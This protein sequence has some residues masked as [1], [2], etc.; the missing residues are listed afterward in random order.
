VRRR[1]K[2]HA[3]RALGGLGYEV[4]I[5]RTRP[6]RSR[7]EFSVSF[8]PYEMKVPAVAAGA[9]RV[10]HVIGNFYTGGSP[11]LVVDLVE[12]LGD[13]YAQTVL[14]RD[15]PSPP[16]YVAP[17]IR[18]EPWLRT[19]DDAARVLEETRPDLVHVHYLGPAFSGIPMGDWQWFTN[20][21][22]AV[23]RWDGPLV[24]NVNI[25]IA[26]HVSGAVD[27]YV[28]VSD[29][30]RTKFGYPDSPSSTIYPGSDVDLFRRDDPAELPD[31]VGMV[32][33]LQGD[34]LDRA[35]IDVFVEVLRRRSATR[36]L[37]VGGGPLL[38]PYEHA[39]AAAGLEDRFTFTGYV[40]YD[41]LPN[42]LR[43][44]GVFVAPVHTESFGHVVPL[45][46]S[47][48]TPVS[49]YDTGALPEILDDASALAPAG[50]VQALA[51]VICGFLDDRSRRLAV[52]AANRER[53]VARFS[54]DE[55]AARYAALYE[56]VLAGAPGS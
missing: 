54:V 56:N 43:R 48:S 30:V 52:G 25:P 15:V 20:V 6:R 19:V 47:M 49:A 33:R 53:A 17:T 34:K 18:V 9:P 14:T 5:I 1:L 11:R 7:A 45:A 2:Q 38:K 4:R 51:D 44:M 32:Y 3:K 36:A 26:P 42:S 29:Y 27:R 55:M 12:R 37:I 41:E 35:A 10:L 39:V 46:M 50:N 8:R 22:R 16:A 21:F 13:R 23:E 31:C 28:F 40:A 24:E